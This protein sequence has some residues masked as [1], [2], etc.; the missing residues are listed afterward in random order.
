MEKWKVYTQEARTQIDFAER[1]WIAFLAAESRE[2]VRNVFFNLQHFLG[3][4]A[5]VNK[6]LEPRLGSERQL[7]LLNHIDLSGLDLK[8]F[9]RLRNHLEHFD[10]RLDK[11]GSKFHG[12]AFFDMN[13]VTGAKGFPES[14][15]LRVLDAHIFKFYGEAYD[16]DQLHNTLVAIESRM[17]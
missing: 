16:L 5:L 13:L 14:A 2:D 9:R 6:I 1:S 12:N 10:E 7:I 3:H 11:W 17:P 15:F 8:P 4:A